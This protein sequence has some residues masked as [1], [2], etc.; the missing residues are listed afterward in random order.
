MGNLRQRRSSVGA[1]RRKFELL[2]ASALVPLSLGVSEPALAACTP[3]GG[4]TIVCTA[5]NYPNINVFAGPAQPISITLDPGVVVTPPYPA[6]T[7]STP[8]TG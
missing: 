8:L 3:P 7:P 2:A 4:N 1:K 5:D 6:L